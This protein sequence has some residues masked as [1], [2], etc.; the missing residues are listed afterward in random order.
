[1]EAGAASVN[2][3]VPDVTAARVRVTEGVMAVNVDTNR[4]PKLDT[5]LYQS[6]NFDASQNRTEINIDSGVGS[7]SVK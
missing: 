2:V 1:V 5:G 3:R 4:F 6:A 7:V